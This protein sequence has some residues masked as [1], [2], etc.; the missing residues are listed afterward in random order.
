MFTLLLGRKLIPEIKYLYFIVW[1]LFW[2]VLFLYICILIDNEYIEIN[3]PLINKS[4]TGTGDLFAALLL[5]WMNLTNNNLKKS[6]ENTVATVQSVLK[7]TIECKYKLKC[8]YQITIVI[9]SFYNRF[10]C[11]QFKEFNKQ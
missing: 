9:F 11:K 3:I 8:N 2:I 4:F 6:I 5:I 1:I 7:R 10:K